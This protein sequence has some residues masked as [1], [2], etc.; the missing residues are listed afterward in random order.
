MKIQERLSVLEDIACSSDG[1]SPRGK[2]RKAARL[3]GADDAQVISSY[4]GSLTAYVH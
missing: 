4:S 2:R 3:P 1:G